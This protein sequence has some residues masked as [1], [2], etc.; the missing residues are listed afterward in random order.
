[1]PFVINDLDDVLIHYELTGVDGPPLVLLHGSG[2]S[3]AVWKQLG[4]V[5][6]LAR[7]HRC[8]LIDLRGHGRSEKPSDEAAYSSRLMVSDVIAVLDRAG[9]E[10]AHVFGYAIGGRIAL[11]LALHAPERVESIIVDDLAVAAAPEEL[12]RLTT[13]VLVIDDERH[14]RAVARVEIVLPRVLSFLER[15]AVAAPIAA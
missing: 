4:Y 3:A 15:V 14:A 8:V 1:M 2:T 12:A 5:E 6:R 11:S 7:H 10:R 13:P 9:I